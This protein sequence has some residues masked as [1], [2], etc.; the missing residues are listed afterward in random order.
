[1]KPREPLH[2]DDDAFL[3]ELAAR[4]SALTPEE[5]QRLERLMRFADVVV[6]R[7]TAVVQGALPPLVVGMLGSTLGTCLSTHPLLEPMFDATTSGWPAPEDPPQQG[8][9]FPE[10]SDELAMSQAGDASLFDLLWALSNAKQPSGSAASLERILFGAVAAF[11]VGALVA[12]E[13]MPPAERAVAL[14]ASAK[15]RALLE[16]HIATL[17][18][19]ARERL[20]RVSLHIDQRE[21][22]PT[23]ETLGLDDQEAHAE[24]MLQLGDWLARD[25]PSPFADPPSR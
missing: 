18:P 12:V 2:P 25:V 11:L 13:R 14:A 9:P 1:M 24:S 15:G 19:A 7:F 6:P 23:M 17:D 20:E 10:R 21:R 22:H 4:P 5:D 16:A 8:P 3:Q